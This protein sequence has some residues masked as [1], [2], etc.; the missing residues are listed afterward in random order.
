MRRGEPGAQ[1][2]SPSSMQQ[3]GAPKGGRR[4]AAAQ[5]GGRA[6]EGSIRRSQEA[7]RPGR[8]TGPCYPEKSTRVSRS[9][10]GWVGAVQDVTG[11]ES[12]RSQES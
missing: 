8:R 4:G 5:T 1:A 3:R 6:R 7:S 10:V 11:P 9:W 2:T 12:G